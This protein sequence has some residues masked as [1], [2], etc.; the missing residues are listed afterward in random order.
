M[1]IE[2][3][4]LRMGTA[5]GLAAWLRE[6]C[7]PA[8]HH[9]ASM[10]GDEAWCVFQDH[11]YHHGLIGHRD[12]LGVKTRSEDVRIMSGSRLEDLNLPRRSMY[13]IYAYIG[14]VLGVNVGIYGIHRVSGL[15]EP[16]HLESRVQIDRHVWLNTTV[17]KSPHVN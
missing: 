15:C 9:E 8:F 7:K 13:A 14:V 11:A 6:E 5:D 3:Q 4:L 10:T 1:R 12:C 16:Q 2:E 17:S